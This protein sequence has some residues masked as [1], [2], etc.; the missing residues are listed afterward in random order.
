MGLT[1]EAQDAVSKGKIKLSAAEH[2]SELEAEKQRSLVKAGKT[3]N[4]DIQQASGKTLKLTTKQV[5]ETLDNAVEDGE[6]K[7]QKIPKFV[8]DWLMDIRDKI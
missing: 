7:G 1:D 6:I 4:K 2:L 8:L 3:T 5:K